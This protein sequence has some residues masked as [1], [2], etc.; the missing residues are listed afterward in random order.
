[1]GRGEFRYDRYTVLLQ[2]AYMQKCWRSQTERGNA[3]VQSTN[4]SAGFGD[5]KTIGVCASD[6]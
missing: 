4:L 6:G 3:G 2:T 1:M 5:L